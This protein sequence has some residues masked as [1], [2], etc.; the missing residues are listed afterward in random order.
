MILKS[1]V[2]V[3][4]KEYSPEFRRMVAKA[5]LTTHKSA[6]ALGKEFKINTVTVLR[7]SRL[8]QDEFSNELAIKQEMSTFKSVINASSPMERADPCA[9]GA[10]H[11][12]A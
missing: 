2:M 3:E 9:D 7:W 1:K 8:Y 11:I 10:A 4:K 12:G 6:G 5:Y